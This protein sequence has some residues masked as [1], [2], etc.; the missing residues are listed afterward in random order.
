MWSN[1]GLDW[2]SHI[3]LDSSLSLTQICYLCCRVCAM[4]LQGRTLVK[5]RQDRV[6]EVPELNVY[7]DPE[8]LLRRSIW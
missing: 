8:D 7:G 4:K 5:T 2:T 3:D 6:S 1:E